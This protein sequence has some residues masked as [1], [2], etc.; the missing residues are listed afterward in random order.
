MRLPFRPAVL[1]I[2]SVILATELAIYLFVK[3]LPAFWI[4]GGIAGGLVGGLAVAD[5]RTYFRA[6][7]SAWAICVVVLALAFLPVGDYVH[8]LAWFVG[9]FAVMSLAF[10]F[11][12][13]AMGCLI[14]EG[15]DA[16][17]KR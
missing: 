1:L 8:C 17:G 11:V 15:P 13:G 14:R 16:L 7:V 10:L 3:V 12:F 9:P 6:A 4:V 5:L 2:A